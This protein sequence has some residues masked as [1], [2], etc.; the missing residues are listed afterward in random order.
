MSVGWQVRLDGLAREYEVPG[1][2][3]AIW[4]K[5]RL[6]T[7]ATGVINLNTAV[8]TTP[9][10]IFQIGSITKLLTAT[11]V[12]QLIEE[13]RLRLDD[14]VRRHV[15]DFSLQSIDAARAITIR[16][17]LTH[18]SGIDGDFFE[19]TGLG[20][21]KLARYIDACRVL[22]T[23]HPPG[24]L[25][26]YCNVGFNL[27]G[28][29]I[30]LQR[31]TTWE[32]A[33]GR[34]LSGRLGDNSFVR[35]PHDTP[36]YRTAIGHVRAKPTD[37]L[38]MTPAAYLPLSSAPA[39]SVVYASA[40]DLILF[41]RT[42]LDGGISPVGEQV[43]SRHTIE[44]MLTPQVHLPV[45]SLADAFG[46][47]F[48]LFDWDHVRV[49]GHDGATTGQNAYLRIVPSRNTAV[50]LLT[51]GGFP[52]ELFHSLFSE[53]FAD[54]LGIRLPARASATVRPPTQ[55]DRYCGVFEKLS[56]R[57][58]VRT[59]HAQ[60]VATIEGTRYPAPPLTYRLRACAPDAFV[61]ALPGSPTSVVFHYLTTAG[62]ARL[63]MTGG[64]VHP[65]RS[66]T[67]SPTIQ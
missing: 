30:E 55:L 8:A 57:I 65:Q 25:F 37:A 27:L 18:T 46:L 60:L 42:L 53:I 17:L 56:Q 35:Y 26:S 40:T 23:L 61:G 34:H 2:S 5:G 6:V 67:D 28:R 38:A 22:P 32:T 49:V 31:G 39:G 14:P 41:A 45:G 1:A 4:H 54:L 63:L 36:K 9:G 11:L 59:E 29:I 20:E 13:G 48:M 10:A 12:M 51:N 62:G 50:A 15:P 7:C 44:Q 47:A 21:D 16:Q 64:R 43:L 19:N 24:E 52:A 33:L 3:L 66:G 58:T